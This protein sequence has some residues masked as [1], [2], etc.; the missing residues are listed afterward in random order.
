M[1]FTNFIKYFVLDIE[2]VLHKAYIN[3]HITLG[4]LNNYF[5]IFAF[6]LPEIKLNINFLILIKFFIFIYC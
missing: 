2:F 1:I 4:I 6:I 3:L 5:I